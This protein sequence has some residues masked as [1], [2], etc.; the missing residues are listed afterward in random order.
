MGRGT[1]VRG[2]PFEAIELD[3]GELF[4]DESD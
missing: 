1:Y 4:G 2:E 3:V